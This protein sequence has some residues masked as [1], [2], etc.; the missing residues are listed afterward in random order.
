MK[1]I[2][3][4][5]F[6]VLI[7]FIA[8][9]SCEN[10]NSKDNLPKLKKIIQFFPSTTDTLRTF[11]FTY[12]GNKLNEI[13]LRNGV[14]YAGFNY[15]GDR[16]ASVYG[17]HATSFEYDNYNRICKYLITGDTLSY[18]YK[19]QLTAFGNHSS[20]WY[21]FKYDSKGNLTESFNTD[22]DFPMG[23]YTYKYDNKKNPIF[24]LKIPPML[25]HE[26]SP[27]SRFDCVLSP[28]NTLQI[29]DNE[30]YTYDYNEYNLP[31]KMYSVVYSHSSQTGLYTP[32]GTILDSEFIYE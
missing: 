26:W 4:L 25:L 14:L 22:Q 28:N 17:T 31:V 5:P 20:D 11:E 21:E 8:N 1:R 23:T 6:L 24:S 19:G 2:F 3:L 18:N 29:N 12:T 13:R 27:F 30:G 9:L 7:L 15:E 10:D 32:V 16:L